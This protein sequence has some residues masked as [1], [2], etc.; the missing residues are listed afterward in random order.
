MRE[1]AFSFPIPLWPG[2][3][4]GTEPRADLGAASS[5][6]CLR[7]AGSRHDNAIAAGPARLPDTPSMV[8]PDAPCPTPGE[9]AG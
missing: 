4:A 7:D 2:E 8:R 9:A 1:S 5:P 6:P 3:T